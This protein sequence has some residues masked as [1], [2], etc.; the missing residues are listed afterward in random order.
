M[1]AVQ[2]GEWFTQVGMVPVRTAVDD[3][4]GTVTW[5]RRLRDKQLDM[6]F[7]RHRDNGLS[8]HPRHCPRSRHPGISAMTADLIRAAVSVAC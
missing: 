3:Q 6:R 7:D 5:P 8:E 2:L 4:Q 1:S